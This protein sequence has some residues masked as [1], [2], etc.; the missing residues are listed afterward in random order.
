MRNHIFNLWLLNIIFLIFLLIS[1]PMDSSGN[2]ETSGS[3][4]TNNL[5]IIIGTV[6]GTYAV[7]LAV[8]VVSLLVAYTKKRKVNKNK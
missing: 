2:D 5:G 1:E 6:L 4:D 3:N 8:V 7:I